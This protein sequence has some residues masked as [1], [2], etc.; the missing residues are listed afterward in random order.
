MLR[1]LTGGL[2][3]LLP[4]VLLGLLVVAVLQPRFIHPRCVEQPGVCDPARL[5]VWDRWSLERQE[6][7]AVRADEALQGLTTALALATPLALQTVPVARLVGLT[8]DWLLL[9]ETAA[10]NWAT[11]EVAQLL[12]QRPRPPLFNREVNTKPLDRQS[13]YTS[14]WSGHTS[15]VATMGTALVLLARSRG[16]RR[17]SFALAAFGVSATLATGVFRILEGRHF[18]LDVLAGA[19][20]GCIVALL[21]ARWQRPAIGQTTR[22]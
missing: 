2:G 1:T 18:L 3:R 12:V 14:F 4:P 6:R 15:Y 16:R 22:T 5:P 11:T 20:A 21:V 17:L 7:W 8:R 13:Q 19:V 10:W 9:A